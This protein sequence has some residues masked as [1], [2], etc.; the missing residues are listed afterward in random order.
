M[1]IP[2]AKSSVS[3]ERVFA[4]TGIAASISDMTTA[5]AM[6]PVVCRKPLCRDKQPRKIIAPRNIHRR[7]NRRTAFKLIPASA[8]RHS[9]CRKIARSSRQT[10]WMERNTDAHFA[11]WPLNPT[12]H[13]LDSTAASKSCEAM[14]FP[15]AQISQCLPGNSACAE[16]CS[17]TSVGISSGEC[18]TS[19]EWEQVVH[20]IF[21]PGYLQS[22]QDDPKIFSRSNGAELSDKSKSNMTLSFISSQINTT[23][24]SFFI[25]L[26]KSNAI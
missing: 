14:A 21:M 10:F 5:S 22:D 25:T 17:T 2:V 26:S 16:A 3:S 13:S 9:S 24:S 19:S 1:R 7:Q 15:P 12:P 6:A 18:M 23:T 4:H 20:S 8:T 11:R